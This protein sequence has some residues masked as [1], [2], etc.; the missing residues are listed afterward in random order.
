MSGAR[1]AVEPVS[2]RSGSFSSQR[3]D[4]SRA[5]SAACAATRKRAKYSV[6]IARADTN[7]HHASARLDG[8]RRARANMSRDS[9]ESSTYSEYARASCEYQMRK[10]LNATNAPVSAPARLETSSRP[11]AAATGIAAM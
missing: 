9:A 7:A 8:D 1:S 11:A 3:H 10:G 6:Q 5:R 2:P 4:R